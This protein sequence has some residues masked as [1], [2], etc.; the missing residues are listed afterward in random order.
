MSPIL[1]LR[2]ELCQALA[3][4][5]DPSIRDAIPDLIAKCDAAEEMA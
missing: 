4:I 2:R 1:R 3:D 5:D